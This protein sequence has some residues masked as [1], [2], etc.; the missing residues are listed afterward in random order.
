M[1]PTFD[2]EELRAQEPKPAAEPVLQQ[3]P[4]LEWASAVGNAAVQRLARSGRYADARL[5]PPSLFPATPTL[6]RQRAGNIWGT[7]EEAPAGQPAGNIWGTGEE[8]PVVLPAP[9][10]A[11]EYAPGGDG[12][13]AGNEVDGEGAGN[14]W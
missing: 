12:E 14:V 4:S 3:R 9:L 8:G 11:D 13:G 10:G 7:G 1:E 6:A 5:A 2:R